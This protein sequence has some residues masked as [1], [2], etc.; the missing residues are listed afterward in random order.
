MLLRKR[1]TSSLLTT[2]SRASS[3]PSCGGVMSTTALPS[4]YSF[5]WQSM[6]WLLLPH[7]LVLALSKWVIA[8][9]VGWNW[10]LFVY[11]QVYRC[12]LIICLDNQ[13]WHSSFFKH[14]FV[15]S[16]MY[17]VLTELRRDTNCGTRNLFHR[18]CAPIPLG[19]CW[20]YFIWR[21]ISYR[22]K[23]LAFSW[24]WNQ[25]WAC[26]LHFNWIIIGVI[27]LWRCSSEF[28]LL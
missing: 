7:F 10:S 23:L 1:P 19:Y 13:G 20:V 12:V 9:I 16:H 11:E 15:S 26:C 28:G 17:S 4:F 18:K 22:T 8:L 2:I 24:T 21:Y 5:S 3:R 27:F 14:N 25:F 6:W